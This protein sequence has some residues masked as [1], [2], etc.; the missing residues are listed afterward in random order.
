MRASSAFHVPSSFI[1]GI[2]DL[3]DEPN[4]TDEALFQ[5]FSEPEALHFYVSRRSLVAPFSL[6]HC[7]IEKSMRRRCRR[8]Q[9]ATHC[10]AAAAVLFDLRLPNA[11]ASVVAVAGLPSVSQS[12]IQREMKEEAET[13]TNY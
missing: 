1:N 3:R 13:L 2:V 11:D 10:T 4:L 9:P 5:T 7:K 8:L 6:T 12:V